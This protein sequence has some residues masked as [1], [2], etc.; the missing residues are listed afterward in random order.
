[1]LGTKDSASDL[2]K[3]LIF[4]AADRTMSNQ[5]PSSIERWGLDLGKG[6][7]DYV[8]KIL[9][10]DPESLNSVHCTYCRNYGPL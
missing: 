4:I 10:L 7:F 1:M 5:N 2:D 8:D 9:K 3:D 6:V